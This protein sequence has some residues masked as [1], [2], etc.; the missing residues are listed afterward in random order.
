[1]FF[2]N[3]LTISAC[4]IATLATLGVATGQGQPAKLT[5]VKLGGQLSDTFLEYVVNR[6]DT[7]AGGKD[8][9]TM[10]Y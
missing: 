1:M 6:A 4:V 5:K 2:R 7:R 3:F 9:I 8:T 10:T